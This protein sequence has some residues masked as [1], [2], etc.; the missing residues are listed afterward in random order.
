L[1]LSLIPA[2]AL[3]TATPGCS[4]PKKATRPPA[5]LDEGDDGA[6]ASEP[7]KTELASKGWGSI[8]GVVSYD[9]T[10]PEIGTLRMRMEEH[11]DKAQCL[12]GK[13]DEIKEQTW[14]IGPNK[15]VANV[16][17]F[18]KAPE[19]KFFKTADEDK[20]RTKPVELRQPHCAFLP[21]VIAVYPVYFDGKEYQKTGEALAVIN[22]AK[23]AHNTSIIGDPIKNPAENPTLPPGDTKTL[24]PKP[25]AKPLDISCSFHKW[26][27]AYCW[28]FDNPYYAVT[29]GQG[30][31]DKAEDFGKFA[32]ARVPAGVE[33]NVVAW[34]PGAGYIWGRDG[35][36]MTFEDGKKTKLD[37]SV[38]K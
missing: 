2:L 19:G 14:I 11:Q 1:I 34:H 37:F 20:K 3:L 28:V 17:I 22:D 5:E 10:L 25:Q 35:K 29:K 24:N 8:E 6:K 13:D 9:G 31:K 21:H 7:T 23:V 27:S 38:K 36:K 15:G 32:I 12:M 4:K 18:L 26:M 33:V 30:E 16:A